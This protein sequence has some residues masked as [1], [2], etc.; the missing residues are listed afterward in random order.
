MAWKCGTCQRNR[1]ANKTQAP[2]LS[3]PHAAAQP[4]NGGMAPG[5]APIMV[6]Q[7][8]R[9]LSGV[10]RPR[11]DMDVATAS[12]AAKAFVASNRSI[13]PAVIKVTPNQTASG[14]ASTPLGS[15]RDAVRRI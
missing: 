10:Y 1:I 2:E 3:D 13:M 11:Y 7:V 9:I 5:N 15:G 4:I 6:A 14:G 12:N 8:V